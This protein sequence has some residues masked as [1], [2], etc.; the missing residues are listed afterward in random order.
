MRYVA[1][2]SGAVLDTK[3][4]LRQWFDSHAEAIEVACKLN[5]REQ[6]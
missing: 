3:T 6:L 1:E 5:A 4:G 2:N